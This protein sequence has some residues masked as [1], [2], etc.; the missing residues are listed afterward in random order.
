VSKVTRLR[1]N[2]N[3]QAAEPTWI[4]KCIVSRSGEVIPNLAN[5]IIALEHVA[6]GWIGYDEMARDIVLLKP[7][8]QTKGFIRRPLRDVDVSYMQETLQHQGMVRLPRDTMFQAMEAHANNHS[9]HPVRD[10]LNGL[11]W[12][13]KN[14]LNSL[15]T[16]Y[17]GAAPSD[18]ARE[19]GKQFLI[20]M[21]ARVFDPGCKADHMLILEGE[22]G[23]L[24]STFCKT[25]AGEWFSDCLPDVQ[26]ASKDAQQHLRNKWLIEV[27]EMSAMGKA[28]AA[29]LKAFVSRDTERYFARYGRLEVV[30]K[31]QV[32]FIGSTN[33]KVY[34]RDETGGRRFWPIKTG[35]IKIDQLKEDRD[36]L[37]AE[38]V[39]RYRAGE[40]WWPDKQFE[41]MHIAPQQAERYEADPWEEPITA[42]LRTQNNVTPTEIARDC[43]ELRF[44]RI[45][46]TDARRITAVLDLLKWAPARR[47]A[48]RRPFV[49]PPGWLEDTE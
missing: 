35:I 20:S 2:K 16:K 4:D 36:Q 41:I 5:A 40:R 14:R 21:V 1:P 46:Q 11:K 24:K 34:L 8:D 44:D 47:R 28:C 9:F 37:F 27:S 12:D 25:L 29:V 26:H 49:P 48:G 23:T 22:Q 38:A 33:K 6:P 43:L 15:A 13:K 31:R 32:V 30:E 42:W 17:L 18:Y 10:Y 3:A 19:V 7:L 45:A 39:A